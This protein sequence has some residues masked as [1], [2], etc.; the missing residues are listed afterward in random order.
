MESGDAEYF[1]ARGRQ[2][3]SI[4]GHFVICAGAEVLCGTGQFSTKHPPACPDM[5]EETETGIEKTAGNSDSTVTYFS[6]ES[7]GCFKLH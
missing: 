4:W 7:S 6:T 2:H 5:F 3:M 1:P